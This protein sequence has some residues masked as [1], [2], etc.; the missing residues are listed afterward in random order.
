MKRSE[1]KETTWIIS[2]VLGVSS[3][4]LS[5]LFVLVG[6]D[7]LVP[8]TMLVLAL[9]TFLAAGASFASK[10]K[11]KI[12]SLIGPFFAL[13]IPLLILVEPHLR[14]STEIIFTHPETGQIIRIVQKKKVERSTLKIVLKL[15]I[16]PRLR[17]LTSKW[18]GRT[19]REKTTPSSAAPFRS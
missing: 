1:S 9:F 6:F 12:L 19:R 17:K 11:K 2:C 4:A 13:A 7:H 16:G 15:P 8:S 18:K 14:G 5:F 10:E 3:I